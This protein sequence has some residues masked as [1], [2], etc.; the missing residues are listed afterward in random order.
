[1]KKKMKFM[2]LTLGMALELSACSYKQAEDSFRN[3]VAEVK[4]EM[5][6]S[7]AESENEVSRNESEENI[8]QIG[9]SAIWTDYYGQ[10]IQ[11]TLESVKTAHNIQE[12]GIVKD[13]FGINARENISDSGEVIS[14]NNEKNILVEAEIKVKNINF[15]GYDNGKSIDMQHIVNID[16]LLDTKENIEEDEPHISAAYFSEH[17]SDDKQY[18]M[19][20]M[21]EGKE[22]IV[23]LVWI[24]PEKYFEEKCYYIIGGA[25]GEHQYFEMN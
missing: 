4:E 3:K 16:T 7:D 9:E 25:N 20:Y 14:D 8:Y 15:K 19:F 5:T 24:V 11:Y 1:M 2:V 12:L 10:E 21:E 17:S 22:K 13:D 23:K 18:F 6:T